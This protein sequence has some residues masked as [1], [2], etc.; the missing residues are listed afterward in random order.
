MVFVLSGKKS[1]IPYFAVTGDSTLDV[2]GDS[3]LDV[4]EEFCVKIGRGV[5][6][7]VTC[8]RVELFSQSD[9]IGLVK[10]YPQSESGKD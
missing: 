6:E 2:T 5:G 4:I 9:I 3:T 7:R 10:D 8:T 1:G